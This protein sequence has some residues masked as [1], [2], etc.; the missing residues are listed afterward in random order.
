MTLL[1][2]SYINVKNVLIYAC[3]HGYENIV[4]DTHPSH[5]IEHITDL[6]YEAMKSNH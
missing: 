6:F 5:M 3:K 1:L 2:M 4:Y